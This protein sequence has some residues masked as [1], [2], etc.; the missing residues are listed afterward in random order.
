MPVS[1]PQNAKLVYDGPR[2]QAWEWEQGL[3]DGSKKTFSCITRED[4]VAVIAFLD[5]ETILLQQEEQPGRAAPFLDVP[6]GVVE[7]GEA[8]ESAAAREL[9]EETGYSSATVRLFR[10]KEFFGMTRFVE[11]VYIATGLTDGQG[12][13]LDA[14]EKIELKPTPWKEAVA[15]SLQGKL[16]RQEAMLAILAM[17]FD[18]EAKKIKKTFLSAA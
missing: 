10:R 15:L 16:R 14:G 4:T 6:G 8:P 12:P 17:E 3:F 13:A 18:P 1:L 2:Q 7:K 5:P 11:D 9:Q